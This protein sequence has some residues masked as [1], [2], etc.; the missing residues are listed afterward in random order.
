VVVESK[1]AIAEEFNLKA[2]SAAADM[3]RAACA[4]KDA[5]VRVGYRFYLSLTPRLKLSACGAAVPLWQ[6][7]TYKLRC[8][9][10]CQQLTAQDGR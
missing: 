4:M 3:S 9:T 1:R 6:L 7:S 8:G 5:I 2:V 10:K